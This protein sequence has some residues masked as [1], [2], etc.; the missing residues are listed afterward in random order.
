MSKPYYSILTNIGENLVAKATALGTKLDLTTMAVGDGNGKLPAP[1]PAQTKLINEKRRAAVNSLEI[2]K[3]NPNII[4]VEHIIPET[5]GG[6]WVREIGL[7]DS[8]GNLIA[9]GNCPETYKPKMIEGSGR[10]QII[11]MMIVVKSTEC[12]ELKSD[13][14]VVLATREYVDGKNEEIKGSVVSELGDSEEKIISQKLVTELFNK[15]GKDLSDAKTLIPASSISTVRQKMVIN[16]LNADA[17]S[18]KGEIVTHRRTKNGWWLVEKIVTGQYSGGASLP[19][20]NCPVWRLGTSFIAP[21]ILTLKQKLAG[22]SENVY[23]YDFTPDQFETGSNKQKVM[24]HQ[25]RGA[26][27]EYIEFTTSTNEKDINIL[28]SATA[29]TDPSMTV[30]VY[31][32]DALISTE[33]ISTV[34]VG[35]KEQFN[36]YITSIN[37]PRKGCE[38]KVK[39]IKNSKEWAYIAGI[40]ANFDNHIADDIDEVYISTY[41]DKAIRTTQSGAMCYVFYEKKAGKFGGESHGGELP[42]LQ[43]FIIDSKEMALD[44]GIFPC[45]SLRVVQETTIDWENGHKIDCFTEHK[46]NSDG[47][48]E[49]AGTF[50]PTE[51][52]NASFAYCPM[53]TV[54][55]AYFKKIR[56]PEYYDLKNHQE[57][58]NIIIDY[59]INSY[60]IQ[61]L[62][63]LYT[64]GILWSTSLEN[65]DSSRVAIKPYVNDSSTKLYAG[66]ST[67]K[68]IELKKFSIHQFRYY[69]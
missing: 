6:W 3:N 4:I 30:E 16:V 69:Y 21:H 29:T 66:L 2:D 44:K 9:V 32:Q 51:G 37:N 31:L 8:E 15:N 13:P 52:F 34:G 45:E 19:S 59:P 36:T 47:T 10:T 43:K 7:F 22:K 40:N 17:F 28:F 62:D 46:F 39:I 56:A 67:G 18:G 55:Y 61:S 63:D 50:E 33:V 48:H 53:F 20:K 25:I 64:A 60:E 41:T 12:I 26:A 1:D 23:Q 68:T 57:G 42:N 58:S 27:G 54:D 11:R 14:S 35:G 24:F 5:E 38:V 49:F 65:V